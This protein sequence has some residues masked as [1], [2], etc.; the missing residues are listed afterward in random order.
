MA[1]RTTTPIVAVTAVATGLLLGG[2]AYAALNTTPSASSTPSSSVADQA[3]QLNDVTA[4]HSAEDPG[5]S[6]AAHD[7][8]EAA[9]KA[10][11]GSD[12]ALENGAAQGQ[13]TT[14]EDH[15]TPATGP[16]RATAPSTTHGDDMRSDTA[17]EHAQDIDKRRSASAS[18]HALHRDSA[19]GTAKSSA[20]D[21]AEDSAQGSDD[22]AEH[23]SATEAGDDHGAASGSDDE[24]AEQESE[25]SGGHHGAD[26]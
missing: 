15:G 19:N 10:A 20:D 5:K 8:A 26:D 11:T 2:T 6:S 23:S 13:G 1:L 21:S 3:Q 16:T 25:R 9:A 14:G 24:H 7:L 17:N 18:A 22:A 12:D 4:G